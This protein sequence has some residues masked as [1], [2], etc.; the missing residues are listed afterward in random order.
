MKSRTAACLVFVAAL[1]SGV[2]AADAGSVFID[3][4]PAGFAVGESIHNH[5]ADGTEAVPA[6]SNAN[7]SPKAW[8]LPTTLDEEIVDLGGNKVWRLSQRDVIGIAGGAPQSP[9]M[10]GP[11][12]EAGAA[13][14]AGRGPVAG[15][16][17]YGQFDFRSA[18]GGTQAGLSIG[19]TAQSFDERHG[20][21]AIQDDGAGFDLRFTET[22]GAGFSSTDLDLNLSY[23][24]WHTVGI[25]IRFMDG[26][27]SGALGDFDAVGNDVVNIYVDG[28]KVHTG[29]SWESLL[30]FFS[31]VESVDTLGF[32]SSVMIP[33]QSG[34]GL[35]FDNVL[36]QD[37]RPVQAVPLP[38]AAWAGLLTL[39]GIAAARRRRRAAQA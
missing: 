22:V 8:F 3:F 31:R 20:F 28:A 17:F 26:L 23:A 1:A 16:V 21:I 35:Y 12:G 11:A 9:H 32:S 10:G 24:D 6:I 4:E 34:G 25:E 19:V 37:F 30:A 7:K 15:D 33:A 38:A 5:Q 36:V 39:G 13:N 27:A 29:T 18:T 2:R 14:N